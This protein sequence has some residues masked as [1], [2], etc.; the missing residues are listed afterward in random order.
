MNDYTFELT[1]GIKME[2]APEETVVELDEE[3]P[4]AVK[5]TA[6]FLCPYALQNGK[7]KVV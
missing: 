6:V 5:R 4:L 1:S 7:R 3:A 2:M